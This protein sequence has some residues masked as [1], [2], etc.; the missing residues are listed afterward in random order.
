[1]QKFII[2]GNLT[3]KPELINNQ[4]GMTIC[5]FGIAENYMNKTNFFTIKTFNKLAENCIKFLQKGSKVAVVGRIDQRE[6]ENKDGLKVKV[7]DEVIAENVEF[8]SNTNQYESE[9][10]NKYTTEY[11]PIESSEKPKSNFVEI[12]DDDLPF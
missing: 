8:L 2:I 11:N 5:K 12:S 1:M 3:R 6:Y 10:D 9:K 4:G 7:C